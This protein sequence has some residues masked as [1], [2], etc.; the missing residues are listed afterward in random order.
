M[1]ASGL[2]YTDP[3]FGVGALL[4]VVTAV[5][6]IHSRLARLSDR[7]NGCAAV[8]LKAIALTV[9]EQARGR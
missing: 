2:Q 3:G 7:S 4:I 6:G 9:S 5:A 8:E 1:R